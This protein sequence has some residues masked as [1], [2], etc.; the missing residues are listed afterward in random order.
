LIFYAIHNLGQKMKRKTIRDLIPSIFLA[1]LMLFSGVLPAKAAAPLFEPADF[2]LIR[3]DEFTMGS[4]EGEVGR[5]EIKAFWEKKGIEY[6]ETQHQVRVSSF[7]M[8]RYAVT[9]ADFRKFVKASGYQ[10]DAERGG[11]SDIVSSGN[12][13]KGD[14]VN[15]RYGVSG[16]VRPLSEENHPVVHV[17]WY[18][19]VAYCKWISS[20][21]GKHFRL[22]TEAEREYACRAGS[23]TQFNTGE[24]LTTA[25]ANYNGNYPYNKNP[26]GVYRDNTVPVNSFAPNGWG[27]YNMHGNVWEWCSDW[28]GGTYY[29]G[30]KTK[31]VVTNPAG[32]ATGSSRVLRGG[33]WGGDAGSCR[34]AN[35]SSGSPDG[36]DDDVGF[37][38]VLVP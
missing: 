28:F 32:P 1:M 14:G 29:D 38:L 35:R 6:S 16:S 19:A 20:K 13:K 25:Q 27:L 22:P 5:A 2:V 7:S 36:Q 30:C 21:T 11:F 33:S 26:A 17:S 37:R 31:G 10:T 4:P 34:S 18:D 8:S 12:I 23:R 24:N 3:G 15:W 9:V